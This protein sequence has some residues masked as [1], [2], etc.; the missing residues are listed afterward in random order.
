MEIKKINVTTPQAEA[1]PGLMAENGVEYVTL[2]EVN[3]PEDYPY[4]P[5]VEVAIAHN[6]EALMIH[7]RVKEQSVRAVAEADHGR[8]WEDSCVEF[9]SM[10]DAEDGIYYN[11]ECNCAGKVLLCAGADRH[12]REKAP[13]EV[14]EKVLR[15]TT[16]GTEPFEERVGETAWE[17]ALVLPREIYFKH[18]V[19]S[20]GDLAIK[21]NVYKCGDMLQ[22]PHFV[23]LFPIAT[24][25]PDFHRPEFFK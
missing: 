5:Q 12:N 7:Y 3:W 14:M 11:V 23:S 9:F 16:L 6:D 19:G 21:A 17:V 24:E 20:I 13:Q 4:C 10:P 1:V 22:V 18:E 15:W 25:K 2:R 8:V